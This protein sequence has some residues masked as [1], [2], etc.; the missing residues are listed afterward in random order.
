ME[1]WLLAFLIS[2]LYVD[3]RSASRPGRFITRVRG[4]LCPVIGEMLCLTAQLDAVLEI[5]TQSYALAA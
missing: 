4:S 2:A 1:V 3:E 5:E